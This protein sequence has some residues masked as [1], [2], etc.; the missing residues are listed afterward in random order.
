MF[1]IDAKTRDY[2]QVMIDKFDALVA[3]KGYPWKLRDIYRKFWWQ[4]KSREHCRLKA[5]Y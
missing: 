3:P 4:E 2:N 5:N 1:P